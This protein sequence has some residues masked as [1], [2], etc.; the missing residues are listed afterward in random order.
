MSPQGFFQ[1][2]GTQIDSLRL[3]CREVAKL[4]LLDTD[5]KTTML[6]HHPEL[7]AYCPCRRIKKCTD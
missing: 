4:R 1:Y 6:V 5:R 3:V 7:W 2:L